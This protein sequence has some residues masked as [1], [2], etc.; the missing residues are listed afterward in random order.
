M[1]EITVHCISSSPLTVRISTLVF[2]GKDDRTIVPL[3]ELRPDIAEAFWLCARVDL[4]ILRKLFYRNFR[5]FAKD[6]GETRLFIRALKG[7][8]FLLPASRVLML[9]PDETARPGRAGRPGSRL[10]KL[11]GGRKKMWTAQTKAKEKTEP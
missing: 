5:R 4:G 3:N 10:Y 9:V 2:C 6:I 7:P 11:E 1:F 8:K